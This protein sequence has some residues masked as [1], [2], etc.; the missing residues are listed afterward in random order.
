M[1]C[2]VCA[3]TTYGKQCTPTP[4]LRVAS[5]AV[6]IMI[7]C[8]YGATTYGEQC[9]PTTQLRVGSNA[10]RIIIRCA[11]AETTCGKQCWPTCVNYKWTNEHTTALLNSANAPSRCQACYELARVN[12]AT[13][14][15]NSLGY[16]DEALMH[17][18]FPLYFRL[19]WTQ[20]RPIHHRG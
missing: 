10:L 5:N 12:F 14:L 8:V 15:P 3:A 4:Q 17:F 6:R 9:A 11:H 16:A 19:P 7:R 2:G 1:Q 20:G 18:L 13:A